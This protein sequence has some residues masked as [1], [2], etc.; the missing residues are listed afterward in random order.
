M[1]QTNCADSAKAP[2][3]G[4]VMLAVGEWI[5]SHSSAPIFD[6]QQLSKELSQF[7]I[8]DISKALACLAE[9]GG[10]RPVFVVRTPSGVIADDVFPDPESIP[11]EIRDRFDHAFLT[12]GSE[13]IPMFQFVR[14]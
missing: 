8:R 4:R 7:A 5:D 9:E 6:P 2:R 3:F 13:I 12:S 14:K 11:P 10:F 1:S